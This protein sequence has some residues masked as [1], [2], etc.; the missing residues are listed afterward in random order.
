MAEK[1]V[2]PGVFTNENDLSFLPAGVAQIGAAFVGP[3]AKGP[4][5]VPVVLRNFEQFKSYFGDLND[6]YYIPYAVRNYLKNSAQVTVVRV[7]SGGGY[8]TNGLSIIS[9]STIVGLLLPTT[10]V[11]ASN[12]TDFSATTGGGA[13]TAGTASL[14]VSGSGVTAQT[15]DISFTSTDTNYLIKVLGK[16]VKGAKKPYAYVYFE[17][18]A[19][20]QASKNFTIISGSASASIDLSGKTT[21]YGKYRPGVTPWITSQLIGT[22]ASKAAQN[23]FRIKTQGDGDLFNRT[24]KISIINNTLAG[25]VPGSDYGYFTILVRDYNDTD[26]RPVVLE[27][28][29]NLNLDPDSANYIA[30]RIGDR[31]Y[32]VDTTSAFG[33]EVVAK[34]EY[35]N[36]S[37]LIYVEVD[38][39][40]KDKAID[41]GLN[42]YGFATVSD[43][44]VVPGCSMPT[45]SIVRSNPEIEGDYSDR[46]YYGWDYTAADNVNYLR[47]IPNGATVGSNVLFNLDESFVS[48]DYGSPKDSQTSPSVGF[49]GSSISGSTLRGLDVSVIAKF[50]VPFQDG[51]DGDDPAV[52]L[53]T[54]ANITSTNAVGMNCDNATTSGSQAYFTALNIMS[55]AETFDINLLA[56]PGINM[57]DHKIVCDKAIDVAATRGDTFVI[58]DPVKQSQTI[59]VAISG[60]ENSLIDSNYAAAYWPW[61]K[62]LDVNKNKPVWVPASTVIPGVI[63]R[64]DASSFEWFAPAGLNRG[65][66]SDA[67]EVEA[68]LSVSQRDSLYDARINPLASFPAQG[69]CVWGQKTLQTKPSALDR[70]NVRRLMITLKKYI[71]SSTRYLVFENNTVETRQRF[72]NIVTPYLENVKARQGLYG[73]RVVMDESNNTPDIIDRN[74][75]YGQIFVQPTKTAEFIV[76]DFNI[77][78]T[79]ATFDNV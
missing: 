6:S 51:F 14:V 3:T 59:G 62:I 20:A 40:V 49:A 45:A 25:N 5:F 48:V 57:A 39:N 17:N 58:L 63:A 32:E 24:Y 30:R 75:L 52:P 46:A 69:V 31:Y 36:I 54:G 60:V 67:L 55:N 35:S 33:A 12:G 18:Y 68:K 78:P 77:L 79:G 11:G 73:F 61:V 16:S 10:K 56:M 26:K 71:A 38:Q 8:I 66:I 4:A 27:T 23:L 37:K 70:V 53:N 1:I 34:G 72:L 50:N 65:G 7:V 74:I 21:D 9:G 19:T 41:P 22:G 44:V 13:V 28:Y 64:S 76:L 47:P 2:S 29:S 43:T 42:P 15:V